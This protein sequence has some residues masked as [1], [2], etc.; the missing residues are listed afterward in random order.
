L[1]RPELSHGDGAANIGLGL[2]TFFR[3]G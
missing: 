2:L 3:M 1:F